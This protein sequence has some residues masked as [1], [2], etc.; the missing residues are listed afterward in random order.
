MPGDGK[1]S[2]GGGGAGGAAASISADASI[3]TGLLA[4]ALAAITL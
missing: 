4:A 1:N 3:F 2:T